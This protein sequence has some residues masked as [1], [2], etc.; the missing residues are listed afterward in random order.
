MGYK[1]E[2][3]FLCLMIIT[4]TATWLSYFIAEGISIYPRSKRNAFSEYTQYSGYQVAC[5]CDL[6]LKKSLEEPHIWMLFLYRQEGNL[7]L[8]EV[9]GIGILSFVSW[10]GK[11]LSHK[12]SSRNPNAVSVQWALRKY[13]NANIGIMCL[14][15]WIYM[16]W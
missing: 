11:S 4:V 3:V 1:A 8:L 10:P 7:H 16:C 15:F 5:F 9:L 13:V 6:M 14:W 12:W 2:N